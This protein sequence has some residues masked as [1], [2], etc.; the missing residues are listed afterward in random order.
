MADDVIVYKLHLN[1]V[2]MINQPLTWFMWQLIHIDVQQFGPD[3]PPYFISQQSSLSGCC[4]PQALNVHW[5]TA[6]STLRIGH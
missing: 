5:V 6:Y 1:P 3:F 4:S 2:N